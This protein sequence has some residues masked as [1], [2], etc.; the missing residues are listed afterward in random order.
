MRN[1]I[2]LAAPLAFALTAC[3]GQR[4]NVGEEVDQLNDE[5]KLIGKGP[6]ERAG[7]QMDDQAKEKADA[8]EDRADALR[9]KADDV[10]DKMEDRAEEIEDTAH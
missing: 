4:E 7:E 9:D 6:A 8:I 10:A 3:D 2:F 1:L 5:G